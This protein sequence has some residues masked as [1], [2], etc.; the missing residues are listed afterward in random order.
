MSDPESEA[1]PQGPVSNLRRR[2]YLTYRY[3]GLRTILFRLLT[4]P[5]RF[6]PLSRRLRLRSNAEDQELKRAVRWYRENGRP[7]DVVIPSYRD[8]DRVRMLVRSIS[9][10]VPRGMARV[11]VTDDCS[12]PEHVA[13]LRRIRGI[14]LVLTAEENSGF[15]ANANRG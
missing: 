2:I 6:T 9:K 13:A 8:A 10:T 5:L 12:G 7:V 14:D 3:H 11:I 1:R 15:A 4:F